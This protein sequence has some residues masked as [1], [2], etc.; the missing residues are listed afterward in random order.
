MRVH[1]MSLHVVF[2]PGGETDRKERMGRDRDEASLPAG[3][4]S[5]DRIRHHVSA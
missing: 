4:V 3:H 5:G 2:R 1:S